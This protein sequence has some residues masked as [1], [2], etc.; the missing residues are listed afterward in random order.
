MQSIVGFDLHDAN[1]D[2]ADDLG[3]IQTA[4]IE[5]RPIFAPLAQ[6]I[7]DN[8]RE[9]LQSRIPFPR[10]NVNHVIDDYITCVDIIDRR[11][12]I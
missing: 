3:A 6:V 12:Q 4:S 11:N 1:D 10:I 9:M 8:C 7:S 2:Y 5:G